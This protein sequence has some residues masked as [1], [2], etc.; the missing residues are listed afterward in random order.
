MVTE[1]Q[2]QAQ[3]NNPHSFSKVELDID[4]NLDVMNDILSDQPDFQ[5]RTGFSG[6]GII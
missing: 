6:K 4:L 2:P 3:E 1:P 5:G